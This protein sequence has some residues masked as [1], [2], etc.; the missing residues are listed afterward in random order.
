MIPN[1]NLVLWYVQQLRLFYLENEIKVAL[2]SNPYSN[3]D[4]KKLAIGGKWKLKIGSQADV[5]FEVCVCLCVF[6]LFHRESFFRLQDVW[7]IPE[8]TDQRCYV[9]SII[10]CAVAKF[11]HLGIW[12]YHISPPKTKTP[13]LTNWRENDMIYMDPRKDDILI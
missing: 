8:G 7:D 2:Q 12:K 4:L 3:L 9:V 13:V 5:L 6:I 11:P 1:W 10:C